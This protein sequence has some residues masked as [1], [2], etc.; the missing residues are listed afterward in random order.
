MLV[1]P[2]GLI[3]NHPNSTVTGKY[4]KKF[5]VTAGAT[6]FDVEYASD[7]N[8][9]INN[10]AW[11]VSIKKISDEIYQFSFDQ[12]IF[13]VYVERINETL[14][15]IWIDHQV[16]DLKIENHRHKI[17]NSFSKIAD[18]SRTISVV[19]APMPGLISK[20]EVKIG[21]IVKPGS[22]LLVLEAMKM[23]NEIRSTDHGRIKSINVKNQMAVEKDQ[24]LLIIEPNS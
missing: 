1:P 5:M 2:S 17:L 19:K 24:I 21:D 3:G 10:K 11:E 13:N 7:S 14:F 4:V 20:I 8:L 12:K 9:S 16:I 22:G 18:V 23:E 6:R 15:R